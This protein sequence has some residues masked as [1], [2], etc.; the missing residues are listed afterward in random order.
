MWM[1]IYWYKDAYISIAYSQFLQEYAILIY[2]LYTSI[3]VATL[4]RYTVMSISKLI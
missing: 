2:A 3:F 4:Q 1:Q